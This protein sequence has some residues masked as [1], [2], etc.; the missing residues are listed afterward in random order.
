MFLCDFWG[1]F[2]D[3]EALVKG[4]VQMGFRFITRTPTAVIIEI[5]R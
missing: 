4:S 2:S 1:S 3:E 5:V